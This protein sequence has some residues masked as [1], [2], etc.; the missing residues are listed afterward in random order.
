M[1]NKFTGLFRYPNPYFSTSADFQF[2]LTLMFSKRLKQ[3]FKGCLRAV[4]VA[5]TTK[6]RPPDVRTTEK[7][8]KKSI[9][10]LCDMPR[11]KM[12]IK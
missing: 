3:R 9:I 11:M 4:Q 8:D 2:I 12:H 10:M 5:Y 1:K 6:G 7:F